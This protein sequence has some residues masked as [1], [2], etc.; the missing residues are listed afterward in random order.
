MGV[1]E[2]AETV[3][4]TV[5]EACEG[6]ENDNSSTISKTISAKVTSNFTDSSSIVEFPGESIANGLDGA[7][8]IIMAGIAGL[9]AI[10]AYVI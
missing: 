9:A 3:T 1:C 8:R 6:D 5:T 4:V 2:T 10:F 7:Q